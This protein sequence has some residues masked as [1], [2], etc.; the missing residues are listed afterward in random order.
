[1]PKI[2]VATS[3]ARARVREAI[4]IARTLN[5]MFPQDPGRGVKRLAL[6]PHHPLSLMYES[7]GEAT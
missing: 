3:S 6:A 2:Q 4:A 7:K 1:M 5:R